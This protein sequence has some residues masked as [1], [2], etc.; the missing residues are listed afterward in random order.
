MI[1]IG[2]AIILLLHGAIHLLG[3]VKEW[4][5]SP[6][7]QLSGKTLIPLS[8]ALKRSVGFLWLMIF[9]ACAT[10]G[11]GLLLDKPWWWPVAAAGIAAS[12]LLIVLYWKD[13]WA[14]TI[15]NILIGIAVFISTA[16]TNLNRMIDSEITALFASTAE[17]RT[18]VFTAERIQHLPP[19][20]Q[21]FIGPSNVMGKETIVSARLKQKGEMR[22]KPDGS[23]MPMVAEHYCTYNMPGFVW[24]GKVDMA[25]FVSLVGKREYADQGALSC[26]NRRFARERDG[27]GDADPLPCRNGMGSVVTCKRIHPMG[28]CRFSLCAS[29]DDLCRRLRIRSLQIQRT[30]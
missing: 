26:D 25:P 15:P 11:I 22:S 9:L 19:C 23:W 20:V 8:D 30:G 13:A 5:L 12:Q 18:E 16:A 29:D 17:T 24:K 14:G 2:I 6:V 3:F 1:R 27:P 7:P 4:N 21:K 28:T 10:G